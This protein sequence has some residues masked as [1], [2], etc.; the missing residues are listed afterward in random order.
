MYDNEEFILPVNCPLYLFVRQQIHDRGIVTSTAHRNLA[1]LCVIEPVSLMDDFSTW[2]YDHWHGLFDLTLEPY[3]RNNNIRFP[4]RWRLADNV[5]IYCRIKNDHL[6]QSTSSS[7]TDRPRTASL[8]VF[9]QDVCNRENNGRADEWLRAL[10]KE[11]IFTFEHLTNLRQSEW[12][13]IKSLPMNAKKLLKLTVDQEREY[14]TGERRQRIINDPTDENSE[15]A[16]S[17]KASGWL[18]FNIKKRKT[19]HLIKTML[20]I[21]KEFVC[22][23]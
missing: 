19:I 18:R 5:Q 13:D 11:D 14:A 17:T 2:Q 7:H 21:I 9:I 22:S 1:H 3:E 15:Q 23:R 20:F 4:T 8:D 16:E 10:E 12:D 6:F